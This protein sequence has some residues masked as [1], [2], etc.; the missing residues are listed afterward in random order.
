MV[1]L[2]LFSLMLE[3]QTSEFQQDIVFNITYLHSMT[4]KQW[5]HYGTKLMVVVEFVGGRY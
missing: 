4:C 1:P 2:K 5:L 3:G